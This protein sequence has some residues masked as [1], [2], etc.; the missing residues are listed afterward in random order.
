MKI[1][2]SYAAAVT[3]LAALIWYYTRKWSLLNW[4]RGGRP[5]LP[6][7]QPG[8]A[9]IV[10][11]PGH[12]EG[13][14]IFTDEQK[15]AMI[16]KVRMVCIRCGGVVQEQ[17]KPFAMLQRVGPFCDGCYDIRRSHLASSSMWPDPLPEKDWAEWRMFTVDFDYEKKFY[18]VLL[19]DGKIV[20]QCWPNSGLMN[21]INSG[22]RYGPRDNIKVRLSHRH[23]MDDD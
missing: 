4:L 9:A 14:H 15:E 18:D 21:A 17:H 10:P 3:A 12:P 22:T 7:P 23:P 6:K 20:E 5:K 11:I 13:I 1:N 16:A 2:W 19:P 8:A